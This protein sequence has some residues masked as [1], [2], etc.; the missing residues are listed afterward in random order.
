MT[1]FKELISTQ[2]ISNKD[3]QYYDAAYNV[4]SDGDY[5]K[6]ITFKLEKPSAITLMVDYVFTDIAIDL[7]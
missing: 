5:V 7:L 6:E 1:N 2:F 3:N 4:D